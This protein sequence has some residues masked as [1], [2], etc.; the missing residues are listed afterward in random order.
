MTSSAEVTARVV[1]PRAPSEVWDA[2][3]D[4][5]GQSRW[6][7]GTR[8]TGGHG[9]GAQVLARTALGPIG[10]TDSMVITHWDPPRRW[11]VRHTGRLVRGLGI[12]AVS[13]AA[14]GSEFRWTEQLQLPFAAAGRLGWRIIR[15]L[16]QAGMDAS[17]RRFA[18]LVSQRDP[19]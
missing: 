13:P 10:F 4:W 6:M 5:P 14:S 15:P 2:V 7:V 8:V 17:L 19:R 16:A 1:V 12:F 3:V 9:L 11:V 18:C